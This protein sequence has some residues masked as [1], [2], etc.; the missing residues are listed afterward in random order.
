MTERASSCT[1]RTRTKRRDGKARPVTLYDVEGYLALAK[2]LKCRLQRPRRPTC[3]A[4]RRQTQD[5]AG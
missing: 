1:I 4:S 3:R 5:F 2:L